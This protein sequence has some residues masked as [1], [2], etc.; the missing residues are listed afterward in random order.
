MF[1]MAGSNLAIASSFDIESVR[2]MRSWYLHRVRMG[3]LLIIANLRI[4]PFEQRIN[5]NDKE[6]GKF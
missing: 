4:A 1:V 5:A 2:S 3:Q 6:P